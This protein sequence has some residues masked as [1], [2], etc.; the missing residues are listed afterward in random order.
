MPR[1]IAVFTSTRAEY[2]LLYWIIKGVAQEQNADLK[3]LVGGMHL[4]P[5][6][7]KTV[8]QIVKDGFAV[9]AKLEFLMSS[10][11]SVGIAKS[12]G[13]AIISAA[14]ALDRLKPDILVVLGDRFEAMAVAQAAMVSQIPIAHIHGGELTE[15]L[16][17][18][19]IRH[20]ITKM[21]HLH[22]T[23]TEEYKKRVIQLGEQPQQVFNYGAPGI[24]NIKSLNLYSRA[25]L[26]ASLNFDISSSP[27]FVVTHH[28]VTLVPNL[29][30]AEMQALL[31]ALS[32]FTEHK[33]I[34]TYP[35]A[36]N[37][38]RDMIQLLEKFASNHPSRIFLKN[39]IG[40]LNYLS[41]LKHCE[42]VIGNSSSGIIEAPSFHIPTINIGKRQQGRT[43]SDTVINCEGKTELISDAIN[44][45]LSEQFKEICRQAKNPYGEGNSSE[46]ILETLISCPL[47]NILFKK[48]Y[49]VESL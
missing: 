6:F 46:K 31:D 26:A 44:I 13:L 18:E 15:G 35:N 29:G 49:D 32:T 22:F 43:Q 41:A 17:D 8:N 10:D 7:G 38:S 23:S 28:P 4:S 25:E 3:L 2:G 21:S 39:S 30:I 47:D 27:F 36:D 34:I 48:F 33:I 14:E 37:E 19:A 40:Q 45:G 1:K 5:E 9:D 24:D 20:S 12:M 16:I 11:S 42:L